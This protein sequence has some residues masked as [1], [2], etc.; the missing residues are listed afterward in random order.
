MKDKWESAVLLTKVK[1]PGSGSINYC[2]THIFHVPLFRDLG[3]KAKIMG[4]K[5]SKSHAIFVYYLVQQAKMP[6]LMAPK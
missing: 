4:R 5:Y 1:N 2:K 3:D 6:K